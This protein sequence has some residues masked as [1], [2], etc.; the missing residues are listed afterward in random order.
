VNTAQL[1]ALLPLIGIAGTSIVLMTATAVRRNRHWSLAITV[2]GLVTSFGL[3]FAARSV[4]PCELEPLLLIDDFALLFFGLLIAASIAVAVLASGYLARRGLPCEELHL[5]L[6]FATLG[7]CVLAASTHFA[8]IFLGLEIHSVS[9]YVLIA[10]SRN[11]DRSLEAGI[12][13]LVLAAVSSAFL[14]FGMALIYAQTG[15][16][17]FTALASLQDGPAAAP[18]LITLA[19]LA[20]LL[21]GIGYKLALVPFHMWTADVYEG[22]P[23]PVAGFVATASKGALVAL[24]VR[25]AATTGDRTTELFVFLALIAG[26]SILV[27]NLLALRQENVKRMLAYSSIAHLGYVMI[28]LL[29]GG[30]RGAEAATFYLAAYFATILGAFGVITVLSPR[31][32]DLDRLEDFIGLGSTRPMLAALLT[33]TLLSLAGIPLTAGFIG[34]F[35]V[36]GAGAGARLWTLALLLVVGSVISVFYYLRVVVAMY[37]R[38]AGDPAPGYAETRV[39]LAAGATLVG[40]ATV[41]LWLGVWPAPFL[42][43]VNAAVGSLF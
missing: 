12:K 38:S 7:C 31:D 1:T 27:G 29:A 8:S 21:V 30:A 22:A 15:T 26:A 17:E 32:R 2:V 43:I 11:A 28:A 39:S 6:L 24:L 16:M 33:A 20:L 36:L 19:G 3:L 5:L 40:L 35:L 4:A 41:L 25:F 14:V 23:A 10:Y 42:E 37:M 34:K 9:L 18:A 13:Y